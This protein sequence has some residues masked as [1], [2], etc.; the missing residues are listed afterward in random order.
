MEGTVKYED[1]KALWK[2]ASY[3]SYLIMPLKYDDAPNKTYIN[4]IF[5]IYEI[6]SEDIGENI[7][8]LFNRKDSGSIGKAYLISGQS[9]ER[10]VFGEVFDRLVVR[11]D[12][13]EGAFSFLDSY[14]YVFHTKVAFLCVGFRYRNMDTFL[15]I[16]NPGY[17]ENKSEFFGYRRSG[18]PHS[19]HLENDLVRFAEKCALHKFF[20]GNSSEVLESYTYTLALL[21]ERFPNIEVMRQATF[22]LHLMENLGKAA[23]DNSEEDLRYVYAVKDQDLGS[24]SWGCCV[25]SQTISYVNGNPEWSLEKAM[26]LQARDGMPV[27]MLAL[28]EKY[29][30]LRFT[31]LLWESADQNQHQLDTLKK[32]MLRFKAY[33]TVDPSN[34]SRW[35]NIKQIYASLLAVNDTARAIE[36]IDSKL[37]ILAEQQQELEQQRTDT[38]FGIITV[39]GVVSI[40]DSMLTIVQALCG[41]QTLDYITVGGTMASLAVVIAVMLRKLKG[42]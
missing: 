8:D 4:D 11:K 40:V 3:A 42:K 36:E 30:C 7:N 34:L 14:L 15:N 20:D 21:P 17:A 26:G 16:C 9:L 19:F 32:L 10:E 18:E 24:Y 38:V 31:E 35:Y 13:R 25:S 2:K 6:C 12:G 1:L 22:N 37:K 28:Y 23:E 29:T 5:D 33:G 41:G 39:F 27:V